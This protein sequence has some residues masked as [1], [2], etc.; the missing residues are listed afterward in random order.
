MNLKLMIP[1]VLAVAFVAAFFAAR[2]GSASGMTSQPAV[3]TANNATL[4]EKVLVNRK[5]LT[6][7]SLSAERRGKFICTDK[8]CLS[9]W[10]PLIVPKG[11]TPSGVSHLGTVRRPDG[12]VQV[13]YRGLPVYTFNGD[14]KPGDVKGNG[15]KDVGVWR[16]AS[17]APTAT[18][19]SPQP[20]PN[21]GYSGYGR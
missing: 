6:L 2:S 16:P 14:Q 4:H 12:R 19:A 20:N 1:L 5:G 21:P 11:T 13:A 15:F 8:G 18:T 17:P 3:G 7:Y 9:A 10:T